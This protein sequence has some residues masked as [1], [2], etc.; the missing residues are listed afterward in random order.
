MR[1]LQNIKI[2]QKLLILIVVSAISLSGIGY[3]GYY[4]LK[5]ISQESEIMYENQL[6]PN[7][8]LGQLRINNRALDS[9][10]LELMITTDKNRNQELNKEITDALKEEGELIKKLT[11]I[12]LPKEQS[13]KLNTYVEKVKELKEQRNN[14]INLAL[15]NKNKEAYALYLDVVAPARSTA[16]S[17]IEELQ[18]SNSD[19]AKS[20]YEKNKNDADQAVNIMI[21]II[22][23]SLAV[24]ILIGIVITRMIVK[25]IAAIQELFFKIEN[26][27]FTVKGS[28]ESKDEIGLLTTSFNNMVQGIRGIITTI[29]VTSEQVAASSEQLSAS[30]EQSTRAS[31]HISTIMQDLAAGSDEQVKSVDESKQIIKEITEYTNQIFGNA[32]TASSTAL[33]TSEMSVE[34]SRSIQ[35]VNL[36]MDSINTTV[37]GLSHAFKGLAERSN[38]IGRINEVITNIAAQTNLLALNAA[39]EAARAGEHGRGFA[40]VADEVRKLAEQSADSAEQI[41]KLIT[42]IQDDTAQT[43]ES[44]TAAALEVEEGLTVVH[45]AGVSFKNIDV[46][47]NEV[48]TQI[49]D[50]VSAVQKLAEG[51]SHVQRSII[52]VNKVAEEAAA[53]TQNV[54]AATQEQLASMEEISA[55]SNSLARMA[56]ELQEMIKQFKI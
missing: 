20:I 32:E 29:G 54:S 39:I 1:L 41:S 4:Y 21:I 23:V 17:L 18:N 55:S 43:M 50:V 40:V 42:I 44:V 46:S 53:G 24:S 9:Y 28:Y 36:Q 51:T 15:V 31:E 34:G 5:F 8:M 26:G 38:E 2:S 7:R 45:E 33:K 11:E 47:I 49:K 35:K 27:D 19:G 25:P 48:V 37:N 6:V 3:L 14:V 30:A 12:N 13:E 10:T 22:I 16:N 56:E 52:E